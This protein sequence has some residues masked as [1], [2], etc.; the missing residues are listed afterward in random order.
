MS[1]FA[2]FGDDALDFYEGLSADNSR[3]YWQTRQD[4]YRRAVAEPLSALAADLSPEFGAVKVFRPYRDLRFS[5]D[6]RPYQEHASIAT[7]PGHDGDAVG[8]L[9]LS[10]SLDG[11]MIAG[12]YYR[13]ARDQ[14]ERFRRLQDDA[15]LA[16][17]L[18]ATLAELRAQGYPLSEGEPLKSAPRGWPRDHARIDLIRR[19]SLI[20][21]RKHEPGPWLFDARCL[22]VIT[23]GWRTAR[24][25]NDWLDRH[26]GGGDLQGH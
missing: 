16:A 7:G 20:V 21:S 3:T 13:P 22:D 25:W 26:V 15:T 23:H 1:T 12:G 4:V 19:T 24:G 5:K 8:G 10:L 17:D 9:Y 2:G 6:K 18:D 11:L 14:L